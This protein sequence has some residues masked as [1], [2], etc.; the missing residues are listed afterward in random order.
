MSRVFTFL[1][2]PLYTA[3]LPKSEYA[4]LILLQLVF[5]VCSFLFA[6]NSGVFFYYSEYKSPRVKRKIFSSWFFY[7]L[8]MFAILIPLA[9]LFYPFVG[10]IFDASQASGFSGTNTYF[11][12]F[13]L[14]LSQLLPFVVY[15][16]YFNFLRIEMRPR[17]AVLVTLADI[18]LMVILVSATLVYTNWG[19]E[20]V[21]LAQLVAKSIVA[22]VVI[23]AEFYKFLIPADFSL[24]ILKKLIAYS[25][26]FFISSSFLWIMNS[27]DKII[28]TQ[29][30]ENHNEV[31]FL[32]LA[33][34]IT[35]PSI[36]LVTAISQALG[37]YVMSIRFDEDAKQ[38]Y[39]EIY[40]LVVLLAA[41]LSI[42]ISSLSPVFIHILA[43]SSFYPALKVIP[44]FA[45]ASVV[46]IMSIQFCVGLNLAKK[47]I[48]IAVAT[49]I[50][51]SL[52]LVA[53]LVFQPI[54]GIAA[55]GWSQIAA[56]GI[57]SVVIYFFAQKYYPIKYRHKWALT[58]L[59]VSIA[60]IGFILSFP[61]EPA[62]FFFYYLTGVVSTGLLVAVATWRFV[63]VK[64]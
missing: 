24:N 19:V 57:A 45:L 41:G 23:C 62:S 26:P 33:M 11:V 44:L 1:L 29:L 38:Q 22:I 55:A 2:I 36:L 56:Y 39:V 4:N 50:G 28:G 63:L 25:Y 40:D 10:N 34:Q 52:G 13:I 31:A 37:P 49:I 59:L 20:G 12:A 8:A 47:T 7:E 64:R 5:A 15:N 14:T 61:P 54:F 6:L 60:S 48:F 43:D 30:L 16:T 21:V 46:N 42:V 18:A 51:G 53:N 17:L 9:V 35:M 3:Y 32:G 58:I 27:S